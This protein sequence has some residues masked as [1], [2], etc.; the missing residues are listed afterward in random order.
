[1]KRMLVLFVM[2]VLIPGLL[3][4]PADVVKKSTNVTTVKGTLRN[5]MDCS[6]SD[7]NTLFILWVMKPVMNLENP[8]KIKMHNTAPDTA[9]VEPTLNPRTPKDVTNIVDFGAMSLNINGAS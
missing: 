1:M 8:R 6:M 2:L 7:L 5:M 4:F 3:V 9:I